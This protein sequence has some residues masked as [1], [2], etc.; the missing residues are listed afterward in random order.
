MEKTSF[1]TRVGGW[2]RVGGHGDGASRSE[3]MIDSALTETD[4]T[5]V[6]SSRRAVSRRDPSGRERV[7]EGFVKVVALVESIQ[8]HMKTQDERTERMVASL[9]R[10]AESLSRMPEQSQ[11]QVESLGRI[12]QQLEDDAA[13]AR[14]LEENLAQLPGLADAQRETMVTVGRQMDELRESGVRSAE[15]LSSFG[16]VISGLQQSTGAA[17]DTLCEI[18]REAA[19]RED[20]LTDLLRDQNR[21]LTLFAYA[22]IAMAA[23]VSLACIAAL[24]K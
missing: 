23:V 17:S 10:I 12:Q 16:E 3:H 14:R 13:Q 1:W 24:L 6:P 4:D 15:S 8:G 9:G 18:Q 2:F 11:A 5:I 20:R 22:A 21:R 19:S 7:E